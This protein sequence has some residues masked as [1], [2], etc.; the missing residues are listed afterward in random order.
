M[1]QG[2]DYIG[3]R[4]KRLLDVAVG[5]AMLVPAS[6]AQTALIASYG[7]RDTRLMSHERSRPDGALFVF[8]KLISVE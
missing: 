7:F 5:S 4:Q 2:I 3:S 1:K 6:I 8:L